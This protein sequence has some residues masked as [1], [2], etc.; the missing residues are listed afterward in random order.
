M[1]D[2]IKVTDGV[3]GEAPAPA[4]PATTKTVDFSAVKAYG[5]TV[6]AATGGVDR[7]AYH[8]GTR[9][10]YTMDLTAYKTTDNYKLEEFI[11]ALKGKVITTQRTSIEFID[12]KVTTSFDAIK[13][14]SISGTVDLNNL[15]TAVN[16]GQTIADAFISI[17]SS[18]NGYSDGSDTAAGTK[19]LKTTALRSELAGNSETVS[20]TQGNMSS[21]T[22]DFKSYFENNNLAIPDGL[23]G[24]G[25]R[26]YCATCSDQWFNFQFKAKDDP[27]DLTRPA[28][29][30]SGA[31]IKTTIIDISEITDV[32]SL[33]EALYNQGGSALETIMDGHSHML[34]FAADPEAGT[35]TVY[36]DRRFNLYA[37]RQYYPHL[38]EKGAKIADGIV[39]DVEKTTRKVFVNDLIIHH[40]DKA[41]MNIH[42]Q[43]PQTSLDHIFS[44]APGTKSMSDFTVMTAAGRE[45]LLGNQAGRKSRDGSRIVPKDEPGL[46]DMAIQYLTD[47]NTI[48]GAQSSR[49]EMTYDNIVIQRET[50]QASE[51]TI[52]D[53]DMA[54]EMADYTRSSVLTQSAQAMLAQANHNGSSVLSLL[55]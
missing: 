51:S 33:V 53:A 45:E 15:R 2:T 44:F 4:I 55:Q 52:R 47:A 16:G 34:H 18:Q 40:T 11:S 35:L 31:D 3:T 32:K 20:I 12:R 54:K 26:V 30:S 8:E 5:G 49:L 21:Y 27:S 50:T 14:T 17:M 42:I 10:S 7:G 25:F 13:H 41:S 37:E 1:G 19:G 28:S 6:T 48:I 46:L 22:I 29:G 36:D 9:A 24:K 23:D 43:I 39:D 38:Q